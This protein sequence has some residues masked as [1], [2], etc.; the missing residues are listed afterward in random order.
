MVDGLGLEEE[1]EGLTDVDVVLTEV[2][3]DGLT[4]EVALL[5]VVDDLTTALVFG[6]GAIGAPL[7]PPD[8]SAVVSVPSY[9]SN[10]GQR[11]TQSLCHPAQTHLNINTRK[12]PILLPTPL[13]HRQ[14]T[15]MPISRIGRRSSRSL[16]VNPNERVAARRRPQSNRTGTKVDIVH[17]VVP[18]S[19]CEV[20]G[21]S[22]LGLDAP[23]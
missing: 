6:V 19:G 14:Q 5:V 22:G 13:I 2:V 3:D 8:R 15:Q 18:D 17:K 4:V 10:G 9:N 16:R 12:V 23:L 20:D 1:D 7:T 11:C 21:V